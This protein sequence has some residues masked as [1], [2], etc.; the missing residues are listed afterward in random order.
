MKQR[1]HNDKN[2][3]W[4]TIYPHTCDNTKH[5]RQTVKDVDGFCISSKCD[6]PGRVSFKLSDPKEEEGGL[7]NII[8]G[9]LRIL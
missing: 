8:S 7:L 3:M 6:L 9:C 2:K 5:M 1:K 4:D